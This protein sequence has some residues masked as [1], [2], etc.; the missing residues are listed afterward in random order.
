MTHQCGKSMAVQSIGAILLF[1]FAFTEDVQDAKVPMSLCDMTVP[2]DQSSFLR[3]LSRGM[4]RARSDY[5]LSFLQAP[6][7]QFSE[8]S[9]SSVVDTQVDTQDDTQDSWSVCSATSNSS[10]IRRMQNL[11]ARAKR[12]RIVGEHAFV[13]TAQLGLYGFVLGASCN[14]I[15]GVENLRSYRFHYNVK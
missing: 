11:E 6:R 2:A 3:K 14:K 9:L 4:T 1:V 7:R 5:R 13:S 8:L 10:F 15:L 12:R